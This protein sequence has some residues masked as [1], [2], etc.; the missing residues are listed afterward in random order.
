VTV[1]VAD[2]VGVPAG[3]P[4]VLYVVDPTVIEKPVPALIEAKSLVDE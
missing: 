4:S 1:E 2:K 3:V